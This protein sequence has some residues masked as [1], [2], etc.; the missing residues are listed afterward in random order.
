MWNKRLKIETIVGPK[1]RL[2]GT[3][4]SKG[5]IRAN[6]FLNGAIADAQEVIVG[7]AGKVEGDTNAKTV[8]V[9][10]DVSGN[11]TDLNNIRALANFQV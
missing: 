5:M 1:T 8:M 2:E 6:G 9:S 4:H 7:R 10:G 3:I 11:I